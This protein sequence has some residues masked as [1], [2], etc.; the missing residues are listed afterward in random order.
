[1][2]RSVAA[3]QDLNNQL[4]GGL[5]SAGSIGASGGFGKSRSP[6]QTPGGGGLVGNQYVPGVYNTQTGYQGMGGGYD[7]NYGLG[8]RRL[9]QSGPM[10]YGISNNQAAPPRP[11]YGL[12]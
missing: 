2:A 8:N 9:S 12:R 4:V 6:A 11:N 3:R 1:M 7:V 5:S 10:Q